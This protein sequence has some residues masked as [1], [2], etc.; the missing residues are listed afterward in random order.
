ML[1][2]RHDDDDDDIYINVCIYINVYMFIYILMY[3]YI[4]IYRKY[5]CIYRKCLYS[6]STNLFN[7][8]CVFMNIYQEVSTEVAFL[9]RQ[10]WLMNKTLIFFG[11]CLLKFDWLIPACFPLVEA[12]LKPIFLYDMNRYHRI[13][14]DVSH[15]FRFVLCVSIQILDMEKGVTVLMNMDRVAPTQSCV[16]HLD[17][18]LDI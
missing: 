1:I 15:F 12:L 13:Y 7:H 8:M 4:Y 5:V 10:K 18:N 2:A 17:C 14:F 16:L 3:I 6:Y 9:S 11:N